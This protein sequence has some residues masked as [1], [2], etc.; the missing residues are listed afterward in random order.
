MFDSFNWGAGVIIVNLIL[1]L[2]I[3]IVVAIAI[4]LIALEWQHRNRPGNDLE[5]RAVNWEKTPTEP[6]R[7]L[8]KGEFELCNRTKTLEIMVPEVT[9]K[10]KLL[11]DGSLANTRVN[12]RIIAAHEATTPRADDYWLAYIVKARQLTRFQVIIDIQSPNLKEL[13]SAW[14]QIRYVTYGPQGRIPKVRHLVIPMQYPDPQ[15]PPTPR[16]VEG[17]GQVFP[18]RT[19][20]L[21]QLDD[22]VEVVQ[23]YVMPHA[24]PGDIVTM[25]ETP[26]ALI[27]GRFRHPTEVKPGWVAVR[28]CYFFMPTSSLAT[29]CGLQTLVDIVGPVRVFGAFVGGA[30]GKVLGHPGGFYELA[31]EQAR[32][33][34]DVTG[35]L[36]PYDQFIVLGP[37]DPQG[38]V[39]RIRQATGLEAAI[40]DVNDLKAVKILAATSGLST[41]LVERSLRSNPAGNADERT[42]LVLIRP[43]SDQSP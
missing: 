13:Q 40:V 14:V 7:L 37:K 41:A 27:Q 36:P 16:P 15:I 30:I 28:I 29:A 5:L 4:I 12:T 18:I 21:A 25:G 39:N 31:G 32:L 19:H 26:L 11:S 22:P 10:V 2:A 17:G 43:E 20:L 34:D 35:T 33:I 23:R 3:A 38:V 24:K 42:P 8:L 1:S 9:A 6:Q